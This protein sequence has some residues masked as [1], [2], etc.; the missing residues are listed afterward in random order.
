M[1]IFIKIYF[2][3]NNFIQHHWAQEDDNE[4][5]NAENTFVKKASTYNPIQAQSDEEASSLQSLPTRV[6]PSK[7]VNASQKPQQQSFV[8]GS[9]VIDVGGYFGSVRYIG[10]VVAAKSADE[11][12]IGVEWDKPGRGKHNGSISDEVGVQHAYFACAD[13][14]GS[15]VKPE[16]LTLLNIEGDDSAT[17]SGGGASAV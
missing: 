17:I 9:R 4:D 13:G 8:V 15:F 3:Q 7:A 16:R 11:I 6:S 10:N 14:M 12:W 1:K 5:D 2:H